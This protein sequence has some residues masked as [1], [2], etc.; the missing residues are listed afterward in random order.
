MLDVSRIK[1]QR[2]DI[3]QDNLDPNVISPVKLSKTSKQNIRNKKNH[4]KLKKNRK[5]KTW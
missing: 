1:I 3:P 2:Q 5:V 4:S